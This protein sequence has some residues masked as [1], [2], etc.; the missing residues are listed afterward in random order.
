[1]IKN[2]KGLRF[3]TFV[4]LLLLLLLLLSLLL[5][6]LLLLFLFKSALYDNEVSGEN[7]VN[8]VSI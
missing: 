7:P 8:F 3:F 2:T 5:L 4:S 6:L 1:M